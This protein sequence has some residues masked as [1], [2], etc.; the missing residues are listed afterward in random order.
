MR[1]TMK[2]LLSTMALLGGVL[3][4]STASADGVLVS[5][6]EL[7]AKERDALAQAIAQHKASNPAIYDK[8]RN[9]EGYKPE[10]YKKFRNPI[11]LVGRE[12]RRLGPE[13]LLPMLEALAFDVWD[14]NGATDVEWRALKVG[15]IEAVSV[16][17]DL[18]SAAVFHAAFIKD[19]DA[20]VLESTAEGMGDLCDDTSFTMLETALNNGKRAAAIEGLGHCRTVEAASLLAAQLDKSANA[21][22]ADRLSRALGFMSSSWAWR[23]LGKSRHAEGLQVRRLASAALVRSYV[24]FDG[25]ARMGAHVGLSMAQHP[26]LRSIVGLNRGTASKKV[27]KSLDVVVATVEKRAKK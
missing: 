1:H 3:F 17:R 16:Q 7:P 23:A 14:R 11:P 20:F 26:D 19:L 12:L 25:V 2:K 10:R 27:L 5:A 8:V 22:E 18:R 21:A 15:L 13:A 9:V 6:D 24:R 4:A